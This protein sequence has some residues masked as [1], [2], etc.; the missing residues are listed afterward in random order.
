VIVLTVLYSEI[1][2][3]IK[4]IEKI[5]KVVLDISGYD[6]FIQVCQMKSILAS[7]VEK[8]LSTDAYTKAIMLMGENWGLHDK[9][10]W[11]DYFSSGF[12]CSNNAELLSP[13][14]IQGAEHLKWARDNMVGLKKVK[15]NFFVYLFLIPHPFTPHAFCLC[16]SVF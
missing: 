7:D 2:G 3:A 8:L 6:A 16:K 13:V 14:Q 5:G 9:K 12:Q 4:M 10:Q 1:N 15:Q 11:I